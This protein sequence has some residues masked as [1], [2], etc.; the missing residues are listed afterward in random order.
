MIYQNVLRG[1]LCLKRPARRWLV[2][3]YWAFILSFIGTLAIVS[4][5]Q[6]PNFIN[7]AFF[8]F[9]W[10]LIVLPM[11]LRSI[12]TFSTRGSD[13]QT[14]M[15]PAESSQGV[16]PCPLDERELSLHYRMHTKAYYIL[17]IFIPVGVLL[18]TPPEI[19]RSAWLVY[20]RIPLL[21]LLSFVVTSLPQTM[22]LWTEPDM[23]PEA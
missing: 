17:Q 12:V 3:V 11:Y 1:I 19:H 23:E 16:I 15:K 9:W 7:Q 10:T 22:I 4:R 5:S 20:L 6:S 8:W 18:L 2:I 21:W 13:L 14:L